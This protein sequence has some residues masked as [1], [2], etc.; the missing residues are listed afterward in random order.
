M[1]NWASDY[2]SSNR[3]T[4]DYAKKNQNI[5]AK[6]E[7]GE[8]IQQTTMEDNEAKSAR[9][10]K[11]ANLPGTDEGE[12]T[13]YIEKARAGGF[14][15]D[16]LKALRAVTDEAMSNENIRGSLKGKQLDLVQQL[17]E[18]AGGGGDSGS[19]RG[20]GSSRRVGGFRRGR[21]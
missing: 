7:N 11:A 17:H 4:F 14:D 18:A 19:N 20:S 8:I 21:R 3:S 2:M 16:D 5:G 12:L 1:N 15:E 10:L 9:S 13:R 6:D